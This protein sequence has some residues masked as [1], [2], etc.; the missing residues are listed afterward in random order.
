M[1]WRLWFRASH[2]Q[3]LARA[4][5]E[6]SSVL[7]KDDLMREEAVFT[8]NVLCTGLISSSDSDSDSSASSSL[9]NT[10]KCL[11]EKE[12][13]EIAPAFTRGSTSMIRELALEIAFAPEK[14]SKCKKRP[15][16]SASIVIQKLNSDKFLAKNSYSNTETSFNILNTQLVAQLDYGIK[17]VSQ[18]HAIQMI[19]IASPKSADIISNPRVLSINQL[20]S[21]IVDTVIP[22]ANV[23]AQITLPKARAVFF[24][25][26]SQDSLTDDEIESEDFSDSDNESFISDTSFDTKPPL[27]RKTEVLGATRRSL[28]SVGIQH[29]QFVLITTKPSSDLVIME[30]YVLNSE[31]SESLKHN[32]GEDFRGHGQ[33]FGTDA[34]NGEDNPCYAVGVW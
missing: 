7:R 33:F 26:T 11:R 6:N 5:N 32:I 1:S 24:V 21:V 25:S 22:N 34:S 15:V 10:D 14:S 28:L 4:R 31:L 9:D 12:S 30:D 27:F 29:Q 16:Q 13:T 3:A 17:F 19:E 20:E 8:H 2:K 23:D 18:T